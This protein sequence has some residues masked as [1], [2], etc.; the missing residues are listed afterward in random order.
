MKWYS[1][2]IC[3]LIIVAGFFCM[4]NMVQIWSR[5]SGVYGEPC[6]IETKNDYEIVGKYD[7]GAIEFISDDNINYISTTE[8]NETKDFNGF[9]E[10]YLL[11]F[12][13]NLCSNTKIYAGQ[14][15][16]IYTMNFYSTKGELVCS[17]VLNITIKVLETKTVISIDMKNE[18]NSY[19]YFTQY[20]AN[21]GAILKV[22]K[23]S[24]V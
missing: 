7:F 19:G 21:N 5:T 17:P 22:V 1:Y 15:D 10:N 16:C 12:N 14:V 2:L 18:N 4:T 13:D 6:T 9:E 23:G 8:F 24:K 11:L 3:C 20:M